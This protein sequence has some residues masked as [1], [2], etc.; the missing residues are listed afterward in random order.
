MMTRKDHPPVNSPPLTTVERLT[1]FRG[2][3]LHDLC[4]AAE[5]AILDGGGFGWVEPPQREVME[6]YWRGVVTVPGRSLIVGRL[7]GVIAGSAQL[8]RPPPNNEAQGF[9]ASLTTFFVAPWGRGHGLAREI[10]EAVEGEARED[11]FET[12]K[13]DVRESQQ[14]AI[15]L[16][17]ALGFEHWGTNPLYARVGGRTLAGLYFTKT[18]NGRPGNDG[19]DSA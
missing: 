8:V 18:I 14:A 19:A 10:I 3:D 11:G 15:Q 7:D 5:L 4:D 12:L 2:A 6:R 1:Q 9:S 17:R 13:L 16:Y